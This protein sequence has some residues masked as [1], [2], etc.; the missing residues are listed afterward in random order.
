MD[1]KSLNEAKE[2]WSQ[3]PDED[4]FQ[5]V[6]DIEDYGNSVRPIILAEADK[7]KKTSDSIPITHSVKLFFDEA[8]AVSNF[9]NKTQIII[10][11]FKRTLDEILAASGIEVEWTNSF[12]NDGTATIKLIEIDTGNRVIRACIGLLPIIANFCGPEASFV[13]E[14]HLTKSGT[15]GQRQYEG[16]ENKACVGTEGCLIFASMWAAGQVAEELKSIILD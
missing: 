11:K 1:E 13:V 14:M 7:R 3:A 4:V 8:G 5:A 2:S 16:K 12:E 15:H 9:D 6:Y 10:R